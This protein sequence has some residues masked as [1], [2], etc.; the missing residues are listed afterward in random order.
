MHDLRLIFIQDSK[1]ELFNHQRQHGNRNLKYAWKNY[2][3]L[4]SLWHAKRYIIVRINEI[5]LIH[6]NYNKTFETWN[7]FSSWTNLNRMPAR[8]RAKNKVTVCY[9]CISGYILTSVLL[10]NSRLLL[11]L[12]SRIIH[13][14]Y[15]AIES[16][17]INPILYKTPRSVVWKI[18]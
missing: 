11:V 14:N 7:H 2:K 8:K 4:P 12:K 16:C 3:R 10:I 5:A 6:Q 13:K 15:P 9:V 17:F 18:I 1:E